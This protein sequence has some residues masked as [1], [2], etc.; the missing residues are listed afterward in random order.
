MSMPWLTILNFFFFFLHDRLWLVSRNAA[1][2]PLSIHA[3]LGG[4][5]CH[6]AD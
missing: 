1:D 3:S 4:A 5:F 6:Q 2:I